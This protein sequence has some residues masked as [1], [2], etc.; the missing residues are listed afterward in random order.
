M[1]WGTI[2]RI[3]PGAKSRVDLGPGMK[4]YPDPTRQVVL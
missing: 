3:G 2:S 1:D 4:S